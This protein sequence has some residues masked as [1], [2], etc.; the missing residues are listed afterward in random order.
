MNLIFQFSQSWYVIF[1]G[2]L[3]SWL[4]L[5]IRRKSYKDKKEV[6]KQLCLGFISFFILV[7]ME[8]FAV[9]MDLWHYTP[10][11][12][13]II[14]WPTYFVAVLFGHQLLKAVDKIC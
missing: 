12:W 11:D 14:L 7:A 9:K 13:P 5:F 3:L 8:I 6:K 2:F 1:F 10:D 4:F